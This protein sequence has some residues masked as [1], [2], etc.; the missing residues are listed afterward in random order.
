MLKIRSDI[1]FAVEILSKFTVYFWIKHVKT[2]N[3]VFYYLNKIIHI[4]IIYSHFS[5]KFSISFDYNNSDYA[6]TV[7]KEDWKLIFRYIFFLA[8]DSVLWSCKC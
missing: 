4:K 1:I 6:E 8:E 3:Q 2:L 7:M 5:F